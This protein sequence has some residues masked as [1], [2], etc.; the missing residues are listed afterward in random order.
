MSNNFEFINA[1]YIMCFRERPVSYDTADPSTCSL[2][3]SGSSYSCLEFDGTGTTDAYYYFTLSS[4]RTTASSLETY[5]PNN[6]TTGT[7]YGSYLISLDG[8]ISTGSIDYLPSTPSIYEVISNE[9]LVF[10]DST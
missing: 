8:T 4:D 3:N 9:E 7:G 1:I 10:T 5:T 2:S 6:V